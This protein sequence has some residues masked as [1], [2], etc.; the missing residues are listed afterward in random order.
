MLYSRPSMVSLRADFIVERVRKR[1]PV[2]TSRKQ[3]GLS[4]GWPSGFT[5]GRGVGGGSTLAGLVTR[6]DLVDHIDFALAAHDLTGR[7][8]LLGGLDGGYDFH[9]KRRTHRTGAA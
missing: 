9:K 2:E 1:L 4:V 5:G 3:T 7:M 6:L 8:A